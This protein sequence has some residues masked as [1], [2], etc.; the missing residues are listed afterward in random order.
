MAK[1]FSVQWLTNYN[2]PIEPKNDK[3]PERARSG[4]HFGIS[5]SN[6]IEINDVG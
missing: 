3:F 2:K 6:S 1:I 5:Q 4:S